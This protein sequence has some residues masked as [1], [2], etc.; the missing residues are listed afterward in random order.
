MMGP[1]RRK[2]CPLCGGKIRVSF[3]YQT[4]HD[5]VLTQKGRLSKRFTRDG[6]HDLE[7][8]IA[9]CLS[10][11]ASWDTDD[12]YVDNGMFFDWKYMEGEE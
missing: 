9:H 10:C 1:V 12:F 2:R 7:A 4:S 8:A 5:Y 6:E 11:D 3:L